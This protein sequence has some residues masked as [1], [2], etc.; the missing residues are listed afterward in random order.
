MLRTIMNAGAGLVLERPTRRKSLP[1]LA[2]ALAKS[3][4][5]VEA[6]LAKLPD[7]AMNRRVLSHIIGIERWGQSRLRVFLGEPLVMDE[8]DGYRPPRDASWDELRQAFT[9][10]RRRTIELVHQLQ[11][12]ASPL[13]KKVPHNQFGPL[14]CR[15]WLRYLDIHARSEARKMR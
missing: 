2:E 9:D 15:A 10:T 4:Q 3:A 13:D 14:T 8:Y 12:A 1:E 11:A 5:K 6:S 7:S